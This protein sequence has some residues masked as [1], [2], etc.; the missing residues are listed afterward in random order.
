MPGAMVATTLKA[1][2]APTPRPIS[3]HMFGCMVVS[4]AQKR[5]KK[6]AAAQTTIGVAR[7]S[8]T[9]SSAR[10][11]MPAKPC[12]ARCRPMAMTTSGRTR[13]A[14]TMKRRRMSRYSALGPCSTETVLGSSAIPQIG[15]SPGPT[16]SISGCIGQV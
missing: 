11:G 3:V 5:L 1:K 13:I 4:D 9:Q 16:C 7:T 12:G 15:Q 6:G 14:P 8:S 2:A 10:A